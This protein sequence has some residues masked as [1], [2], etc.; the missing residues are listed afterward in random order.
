MNQTIQDLFSLGCIVVI[1]F[2]LAQVSISYAQ[3]KVWNHGTCKRFNSPWI[4]YK[5]IK[6]GD[7]IY[8]IY[9]AGDFN[10]LLDWAGD[11]KSTDERKCL[12][13]ISPVAE[14]L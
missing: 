8:T 11:V 5:K 6:D 2:V 12:I 7:D 10:Y 4:E 1:L 3:V 14:F 13:F 9:Y